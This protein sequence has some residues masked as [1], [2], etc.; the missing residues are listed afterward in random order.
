MSVF[1]RHKN[2]HFPKILKPRQIFISALEAISVLLQTACSEISSC[3]SVKTR[4]ILDLG[5]QRSYITRRLK[6]A[7]QLQKIRSENLLIKTFG[8]A[9]EQF[10]VSDVVQVA[11]KGRSDDLNMYVTCYTVPTICTPLDHLPLKLAAASCPHLNVLLLADSSSAEGVLEIEMLIG[12]DFS[13]TWL[14]GVWYGGVESCRHGNKIGIFSFWTG[15][16]RTHGRFNCRQHHFRPYYYDGSSTFSSWRE[17]KGTF[18][19]LLEV[20]LHWR[21]SRREFGSGQVWGD[22]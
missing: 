20:R 6:G 11:L 18:K 12:A 17:F 2:R 13:G 22:S 16:W 19:P 3:P 15:L 1:V 14:L 4:V 7:L 5:S 21:S 10:W 9:S 8:S